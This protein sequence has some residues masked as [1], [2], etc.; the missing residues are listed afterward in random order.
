MVTVREPIPWRGLRPRILAAPPGHDAAQRAESKNAR[1]GRD[2]CSLFGLALE[3]QLE[4]DQRRAIAHYTEAIKLE[5]RAADAYVNRAAA[6]QSWGDLELALR[7]LDQALALEASP[8]AYNNRGNIHF[9]KGD[10]DR[11]VRDYS[12]AVNLE[13][14]NVSAYVGRGHSLRLLSIYGHA[15]RS[16]SEAL[17][18]IRDREGAPARHGADAHLGLG[19]VYSLMGENDTAISHYDRAIE[20]DPE[21]PLAYLSRGVAHERNGDPELGNGGLQPDPVLK[22]QRYG[23]PESRLCPA[24]PLGLGWGPLGPS[25]RPQ[26]GDGPGVVVPR[27]ARGRCLLREEAPRQAAGAHGGH[28]ER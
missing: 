22:T 4:G 12:E 13:P 10:Y 6:H 2:Y 16:Y 1:S 9:L 3:C 24:A 19:A 20:F 17:D 26:H 5:P 25:P 14:G 23:V 27:R 11:A 18:V 28:G 21:D 8:E 7:D 15:I